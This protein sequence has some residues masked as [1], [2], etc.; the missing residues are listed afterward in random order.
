MFESTSRYY[1]LETARHETKDGQAI[2]Y[3]RRRFLPRGESMPTL[4]EI[5][6][7]D[8]DRLDL[9]AARTLGSAEHF[10]QICDKENAMNPRD[11]TSEPAR[12]LRVPV[13]QV[14]R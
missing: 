1:S 12:V 9:I 13:P 10:W 8:G 14:N 6:V 5:T 3:K 7:V 11:L 2:A 4:V